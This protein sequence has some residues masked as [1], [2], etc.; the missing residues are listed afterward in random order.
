MSTELQTMTEQQLVAVDV[1]S[2]GT[3]ITE[4][5]LEKA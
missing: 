3:G 2:D 4:L 5:T 1:M